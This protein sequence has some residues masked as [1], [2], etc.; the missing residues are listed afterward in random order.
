VNLSSCRPL[1]PWGTLTWSAAPS[2]ELGWAMVDGQPSAGDVQAGQGSRALISLGARAVLQ[3]GRGHALQGRLALEAGTAL[4]S[5]T[6]NV[7][8][9]SVSALRGPYLL[10]NLGLAF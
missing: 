2:G 8:T 6:A 7:N 5:V 1:T 10:L 4:R 9:A 3:G